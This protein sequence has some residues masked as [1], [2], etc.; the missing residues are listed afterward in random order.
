VDKKEIHKDK[1]DVSRDLKVLRSKLFM[2]FIER[3]KNILR[4]NNPGNGKCA[5]ICSGDP[6]VSHRQHLV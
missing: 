3:M 5:V 4:A 1:K 2:G 6:V